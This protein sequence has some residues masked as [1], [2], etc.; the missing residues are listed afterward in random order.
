MIL[1]RL[2]ASGLAPLTLLGALLAYWYPPLFLI[3]KDSFLWFFAAT[4]F[5]LGV[6]L[7]PDDLRDTL[8]H[9]GRIGILQHG[10]CTFC[11]NIGFFY[12]IRIHH[13]ILSR[14]KRA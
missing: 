2:L 1:F 7:N 12:R 14:F 10:C 5:A 4:M 8:Q 13:S 6:V 9:P 11:V 3:F